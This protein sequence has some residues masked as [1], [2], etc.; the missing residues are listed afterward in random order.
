MQQ[1]AAAVGSTRQ[2]WGLGLGQDPR[3]QLPTSLC[4]LRP[5][6]GY[7]IRGVFYGWN[8][9]HGHFLP[10]PPSYLPVEDVNH[11]GRSCSGRAAAPGA[12]PTPR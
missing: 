6:P 5:D 10:R 7:H 12:P 8:P 9:T 1:R 2:P 11:S 4:H 3:G